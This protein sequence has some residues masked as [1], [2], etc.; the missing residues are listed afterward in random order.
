MI[1]TLA[2]SF[3]HILIVLIVLSLPASL[4][5][6]LF[7]SRKNDDQLHS[8]SEIGSIGKMDVSQNLNEQES[9]KLE[10]MGRTSEKTNLILYV[11]TCI[12]IFVISS[13]NIASKR[14]IE[15]F[16]DWAYL[17]GTIVAI[18][19]ASI[20]NILI[21]TLLFNPLRKLNKRFLLFNDGRIDRGTFNKLRNRTKTHTI[22]VSVIGVPLTLGIFGLFLIPHYKFLSNL[23]KLNL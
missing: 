4:I 11:F 9:E 1:T 5:Y 10:K 22:I 16:D 6:L 12:F 2:I 21:F 23:K 8:T 20:L 19:F 7:K 18:V 15:R 14:N 3:Q 13:A 17:T